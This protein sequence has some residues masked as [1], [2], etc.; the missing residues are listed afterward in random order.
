MEPSSVR[1]EPGDPARI[2][3]YTV[4]GRLGAGA[5]GQVY[6]ATSPG[7]RLVAVKTIHPELAGSDDFRVR[8]GHEFAAAQ[9]VNGVY[10]AGVIDAGLDAPIPWLATAYVPAPAL[11]NLVRRCGPLSAEGVGWLAA[12][13][14]EAVHAIHRAG[15]VH[16]DIKPSNILLAADGVKVI[17][18]GLARAT[19]R[20]P[21]TIPGRTVGTPSYMAPE[22]AEGRWPVGPAA[23]V[24]ALGATLQFAATGRADARSEALAEA[25][26]A[27]PV[28]LRDIIE[29]CLHPDAR[30]RPSA[31]DVLSLAADLVAHDS[32]CPPLSRTAWHMIDGYALGPD[33]VREERTVEPEAAKDTTPDAATPGLGP[34]PRP[35][36]RAP[37]RA[38]RLRRSPPALQGVVV[39]I[40]AIA[41][42]LGAGMG[43]LAAAERDDHRPPPPGPGFG[44][45]PGGP[46]G[47]QSFGSPPPFSGR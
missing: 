30:M 10:T 41:L 28:E 43:W 40:A 7:G 45:P 14:A 9:R 21:L 34:G 22:Q 23:D 35:G 13:C 5:M 12:G 11:D 24:F 26:A 29:P 25:M 19:E 36:R 4:L 17:D 47:Y 1:P 31:Q 2:G 15:L 32:R 27:L 37:R 8:F 3:A 46:G 38:Q 33:R 39:A 6:L 16:R 20:P 42:A 44:G 18:F